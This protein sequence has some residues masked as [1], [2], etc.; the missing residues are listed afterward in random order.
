MIRRVLPAMM[1]LSGLAL[2]SDVGYVCTL[3]MPEY[4]E[5]EDA[6]LADLNGDGN[7]DLLVGASNR[8]RLYRRSLR[9]H[10]KIDAGVCFNVEPSLVY[11]LTPDVVAFAAGDVEVDPGNEV[12]LF[13]ATGVY[14]WPTV[15]GVEVRPRE[16]WAVLSEGER[17]SV[18]EAGG[19][20][21]SSPLLSAGFK[22]GARV[23]FDLP[24]REHLRL[25]IDLSVESWLGGAAP[26][27]AALRISGQRQFG[28][29]GVELRGGVGLGIEFGH[30][31]D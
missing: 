8:A 12:V 6:L 1:L 23:R 19:T 3:P 29:G 4:H 17:Q 11:D 16:P 26:S 13:T 24:K 2:A 28:L 18:N 30:T 31:R 9:V 10:L 21:F 15:K 20:S 22:T 5:V 7:E 25:F 14:A 27:F